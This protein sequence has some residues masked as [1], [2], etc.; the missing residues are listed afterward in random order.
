MNEE[1]AVSTALERGVLSGQ[2]VLSVHATLAIP[3]V[4]PALQID[5]EIHLHSP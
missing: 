4:L 1:K 2:E 5:G 3:T